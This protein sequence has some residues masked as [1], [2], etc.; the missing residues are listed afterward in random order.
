M[1]YILIV[2][3]SMIIWQRFLYCQSLKCK[4]QK[5]QISTCSSMECSAKRFIGDVKLLD[6]KFHSFRGRKVGCLK[7]TSMSVLK[8]YS[9]TSPLSPLGILT[10]CKLLFLT[11]FHFP[12][13]KGLHIHIRDIFLI[14]KKQF[15][16]LQV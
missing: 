10:H 7:T 1:S 15:S 3:K 8:N 2:I 4:K 13:F 11:N 6:D 5:Y 14:S 9:T 16:L 12:T